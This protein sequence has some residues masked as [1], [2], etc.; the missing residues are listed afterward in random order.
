MRGREG[1]ASQG[2]GGEKNREESERKD[3]APPIPLL[4]QGTAVTTPYT[5]SPVCLLLLSSPPSLALSHDSTLLPPSAAKSRPLILPQASATRPPPPLFFF[6]K[7][8]AKLA[9]AP[10][11]TRLG[12]PRGDGREGDC[13][14]RREGGGAA[15]RTCSATIVQL[16]N[17]ICP[18]SV[19]P[20]LKRTG[21]MD[22]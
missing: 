7:W 5:H 22:T 16:S 4:P 1:P 13:D 8:E 2:G 18:P 14:G 11:G 3:A 12:R 20:V 10:L 6:S 9:G 17:L 15:M 21:M 19:L